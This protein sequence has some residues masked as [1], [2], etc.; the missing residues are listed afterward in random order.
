MIVPT[1]YTKYAEW[2]IEF[3]LTMKQIET[4][5][6]L[7]VPFTEKRNLVPTWNTPTSH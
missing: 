1:H 2:M 7:P 4:R 5:V 3:E 6:K